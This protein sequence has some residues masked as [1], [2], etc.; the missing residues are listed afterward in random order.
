MVTGKIHLVSGLYNI[1]DLFILPKYLFIW[2][3]IRVLN[4]RPRLNN[5][6]L[7][8]SYQSLFKKYSNGG[9]PIKNVYAEFGNNL[10]NK[11]IK[12]M[13]SWNKIPRAQLNKE[14]CKNYFHAKKITIHIYVNNFI[15]VH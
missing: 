7:S 2:I 13:L 1:L 12:N 15:Q 4:K 8:V 10:N 6:I 3:T 11:F 5:N 9:E 14:F